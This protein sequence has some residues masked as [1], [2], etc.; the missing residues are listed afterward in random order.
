MIDFM[1]FVDRLA[2]ELIFGG[3]RT[4][5]DEKEDDDLPSPVEHRLRRLSNHTLY[6]DA[7]KKVQVLLFLS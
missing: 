6:L 1:E 3:R 5:S 7:P 4:R 2:W